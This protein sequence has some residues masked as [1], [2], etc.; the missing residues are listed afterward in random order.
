MATAL[1]HGVRGLAPL[2]RAVVASA[3][4][5]VISKRSA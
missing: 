3:F 4:S 1:I 2:R 5:L